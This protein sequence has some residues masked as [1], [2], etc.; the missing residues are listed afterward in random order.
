[1]S[2]RQMAVDRDA[3]LC[4]ST[5]NLFMKHEKRQLSADE[6][7]FDETRGDECNE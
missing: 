3:S 7:S 4:N 6:M 5:G 2:G 1:M